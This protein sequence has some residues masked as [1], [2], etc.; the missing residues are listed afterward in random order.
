[1][2]LKIDWRDVGR[3]KRNVFSLFFLVDHVQKQVFSSYLLATNNVGT[4]VYHLKPF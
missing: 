1:M 4:G 2:S 3:L